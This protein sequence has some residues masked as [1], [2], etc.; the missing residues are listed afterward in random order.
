MWRQVS[1][2]RG[3]WG[4]QVGVVRWGGDV[5]GWGDGFVLDSHLLM[6]MLGDSS[7]HGE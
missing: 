4:A 3:G 5:S 6:M 7:T 2:G 1:G